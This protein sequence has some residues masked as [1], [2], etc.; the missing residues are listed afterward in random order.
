MENY[1]PWC[2][3]ANS[4]LFI[5][6]NGFFSLFS[7]FDS[8]LSDGFSEV[9]LAGIWLFPSS[10]SWICFSLLNNSSKYYFYFHD[11]QWRWRAL[12]HVTELESNHYR[13]RLGRFCRIEEFWC[14]ILWL[15]W[16]FLYG[17]IKIILNMILKGQLYRRTM[18]SSENSPM[19][20]KLRLKAAQKIS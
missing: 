5:G 7:V 14:R 12:G 20:L 1:K 16:L 4:S 13:S 2:L 8:F 15:K 3:T 18:K 6:E 9:F 17:I 10:D 11:D 19:L